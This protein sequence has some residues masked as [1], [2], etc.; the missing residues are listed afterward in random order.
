LVNAARRP[1]EWQS[2]DIVFEAPRFENGTL[3]RPAMQTVFWNGVVVHNRKEAIG[4]TVYRQVARYTPHAAQMPLMLQ[5]H[6]NPVRYRNI[7]IR[8][9]GAYDQPSGK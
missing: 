7:W 8:R 3:V 6:A 5:D 4:A 1:G 9:L 2:Y